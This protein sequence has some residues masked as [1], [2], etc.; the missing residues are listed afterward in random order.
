VRRV[1]L[2]VYYST[3]HTITPETPHELA[4][5]AGDRVSIVPNADIIYHGPVLPESEHE[6]PEVHR[7]VLEL[8]EGTDLED[9]A[10]YFVDRLDGRI[11]RLTVHRHEVELSENALT[12][13][14][15]MEMGNRFTDESGREWRVSLEM[16]GLTE[17]SMGRFQTSGAQL[18]H[19]AAQIVFR[20]GDEVLTEEYTSLTPVKDL[21]KG[22][23]KQWYRAA[24]KRR[25]REEK[26]EAGA[27]S[28]TH[29]AEHDEDKESN[30]EAEREGDGS[31]AEGDTRLRHEEGTEPEI[32]PIEGDETL[33]DADPVPQGDEPDDVRRD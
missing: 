17:E 28:I 22:D 30:A 6:V 2:I 8:T 10:D 9:V 11:D 21:D 13:A 15:E 31:R 18:P 7:F 23:L 24:R 5:R 14:L 25:E 1:E 12:D 33:P 32:R 3:D 20:S 27:A 29:F 19:L 4:G 16:L 26:D